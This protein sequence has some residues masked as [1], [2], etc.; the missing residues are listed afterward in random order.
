V[1]VER[2]ALEDHRDVAVFRREVG[3]VAI[4]DADRA[5][6]D[7]LEPGDHAQHRGLTATRRPDEHEKLRVVHVQV[8]GV[9]C[10]VVHADK[11]PCGFLQLHG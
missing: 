4:A 1:R 8:D 10:R 7:G 5:R 9:D 11:L 6:V 2:V 3:D